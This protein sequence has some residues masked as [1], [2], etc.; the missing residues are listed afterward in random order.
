MWEQ[1]LRAA[2]RRIVDI[3][4]TEN[5]GEV[6]K[7]VTKPGAYLK[8]DDAGAWW[9]DPERLETLHYALGS[10]RLIG[11][12]RSLSGIRRKLGFVEAEDFDDLVAID[13]DD[14]EAWVPCREVLYRCQRGG[15]GRPSPVDDQAVHGARPRRVRSRRELV[16]LGGRP[17]P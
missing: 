2:G 5:S 10:R 15:P 6:A 3:R 13:F 7:Y 16:G 1:C 9:C 4:V 11:W 12:S 14:G 17:G 8:L